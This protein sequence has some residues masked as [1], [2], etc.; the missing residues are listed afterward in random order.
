MKNDEAI[1]KESVKQIGTVR[2]VRGDVVEVEIGAIENLPQINELLRSVEDPDVRLEVYCQ[3]DTVSTCLILSKG[4]KIYRGMAIGTTGETL[5]LGVDSKLLGRVINIFGQAQ[6]GKEEIDYKKKISVHGTKTQYSKVKN[7]LEVL[8]TGIKVIDFLVPFVRGG[9]IGFIGGAGVGKTI[10]MTEMIHNITQRHQGVSV[11]AGVGERIREGQELYQRLV[12]ANVMKDTVMIL[13]QMNENAVVRSRSA[14]AAVS[15]AEYFRDEHKKEVLFFVDNMYRF[16][17]AGNE[18]STLIGTLP[19]EQSYQATLQSEISHLEDRLIST[20]DASI[21]TIQTVYLPAD[22][23]NDPGVVSILPFLDTTLF[24]SRSVA[25]MGINPPVDI[26][27]SSSAAVSRNMISTE[28]FQLLTSF[29]QLLDRYNKIS[30]IIAIVGQ[31]ELSAQDQLLFERVNKVI[32]YMTQ[33]FFSTETQTSRK[34][35]FVPAATTVS[36]VKSILSGKMDRVPADK[37]LY[38]GSLTDIK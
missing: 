22:E 1:Q 20:E 38:I 18:V 28:H 14:M 36:D 26:N 10:L 15:L 34:G 35:V 19:S 8:E 21:T 3:T 30:H 25:Q 7:K 37:F 23:T 29:R 16:I 5:S 4:I 2:M 33:P 17:Q 11:F 32:N 13:G 6:D 27:I 9:K 31:S 24:L 12:E